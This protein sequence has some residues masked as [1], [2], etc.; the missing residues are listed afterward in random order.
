MPFS[1]TYPARMAAFL[2]RHGTTDVPGIFHAVRNLPY[3]SSGERSPDAVMATGRGACTAKHILLRDLLRHIGEVAAVEIVGGDFAAG[4]PPH[5]S[6]PA[7]LLQML[8]EG[9]IHDFHCYTVWRGPERELA[10]DATWP[11]A[12]EPYGYPVNSNWAGE[13][14]TKLAIRPTNVKA[15]EEDVPAAKQRLL[16]A[17]TADEVADRAA[18]L[19]HLSDWMAATIWTGDRTGG[20][21]A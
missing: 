5:P 15:R 14:D 9:G 10:L 1:D 13:G 12:V 17:L 18:F 21:G 16:G 20:T 11:D 6:M 8:A 19:K 3:H 7:P 4:I 2:A